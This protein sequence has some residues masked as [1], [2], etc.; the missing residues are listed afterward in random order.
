M[1]RST[2][3]HF[4][5]PAGSAVAHT[6]SERRLQQLTDKGTSA[7]QAAPRRP[8]RA[9]ARARRAQSS[10]AQSL[11]VQSRPSPPDAIMG[12][13]GWQL[14]AST[15]SQ[16]PV[17]GASGPS[18]PSSTCTSCGARARAAVSRDGGARCAATSRAGARR[19]RRAARLP[20]VEV[21]NVDAVV[22]RAAHHPRALAPGHRERGKHRVQLV[23][24]A[25]AR[26]PRRPACH[27]VRAR[28]QAC[29]GQP[30]TLTL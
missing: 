13:V 10:S 26:P 29:A 19:G 11:T 27:V 14:T 6:R 7:W 22:L 16:W 9:T 2:S 4:H 8:A 28:V 18:R 23:L 25:C 15:A 3:M 1:P 12:S 21:P 5:M 20:A 24:V 30:Y 17:P